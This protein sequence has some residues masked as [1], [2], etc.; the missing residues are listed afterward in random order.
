MNS[1]LQETQTKLKDVR[2][3]IHM[4]QQGK[5]LNIQEEAE[6]DEDEEDTPLDRY[7][8]QKARGELIKS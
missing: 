8:K 6:E 1:E 4:L 7:D 2:N 3:S 5:P